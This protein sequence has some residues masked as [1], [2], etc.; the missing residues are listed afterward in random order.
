MEQSF[1]CLHVEGLTGIVPHTAMWDASFM[2]KVG[3]T[4]HNTSKTQEPVCDF[5]C[6]VALAAF[7]AETA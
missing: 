7:V 1:T 5:P 3:V 2:G 6:V 4:F